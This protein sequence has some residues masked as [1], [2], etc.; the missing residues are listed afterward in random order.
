ML[1][2]NRAAIHH[3]GL[4]RDA[5]VD[6]FVE[7]PHFTSLHKINLIAWRHSM[8]DTQSHLYT[9]FTVFAEVQSYPPFHTH[10]D[11]AG[12]CSFC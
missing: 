3:S 7:K 2:R 8:A 11:E 12:H 4:T 6:E 10:R 1:P 5:I 9:P